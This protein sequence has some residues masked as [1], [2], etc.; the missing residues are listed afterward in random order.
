[1][2]KRFLVQGWPAFWQM[3]LVI[4]ITGATA[5]VR[6]AG[7]Q[8][9]WEAGLGFGG[10]AYPHYP[11]SAEYRTL[12]LPIPYWVYRGEYLELDRDG[13]RGLLYRSDRVELDFS[14]DATLPVNS[15]SN[16]RAGM[17]KLNPLIE[18]GPSLNVMVWRSAHYD[19]SVQI[20]LPV[21]A[22][23]SVASGLQTAS[24]G[25]RLAPDLYLEDRQ[26]GR[27]GQWHRTLALGPVFS[28]RQ[29]HNY[30]YRV[31][32]Q[33]VLPERPAFEAP[34]GYSGF[35]TSFATARRF[36][37]VWVGLYVSVDDFSGAVFR[38]SALVERRHAVVGGLGFSWILAESRRLAPY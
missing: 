27:S 6:A 15:D 29:L 37:Q 21:R 11:G 26:A 35:R 18:F 20:R 2:R 30:F 9:L 4:L 16:L 7:Q 24:Q 14:F 17:A 10:A 5:Q 33:D 38:D 19:R 36:K 12:A 23:V 8:P 31:A 32:E 13:L 28:D 1:M 3:L 34:S 22:A 25:W